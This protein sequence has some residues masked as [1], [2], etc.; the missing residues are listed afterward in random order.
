VVALVACA[1]TVFALAAEPPGQARR[2][3][4]G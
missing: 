3:K 1:V 2:R 4:T